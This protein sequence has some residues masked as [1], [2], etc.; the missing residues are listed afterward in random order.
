MAVWVVQKQFHFGESI[1]EMN[2][3][4]L[5]FW[6]EGAM[7]IYEFEAKIRIPRIG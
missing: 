2:V 3:E 1:W 5:M 6:F 4:K 7:K